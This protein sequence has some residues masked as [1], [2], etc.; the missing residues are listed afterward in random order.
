MIR[1]PTHGMP[2]DPGKMCAEEILAP[3]GSVC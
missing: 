2:T 1:I 3:L